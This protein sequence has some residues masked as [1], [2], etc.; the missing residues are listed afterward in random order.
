M[1]YEQRFR[2]IMQALQTG[3]VTPERFLRAATGHLANGQEGLS[4][5]MKDLGLATTEYGPPPNVAANGPTVPE[6]D[7][8]TLSRGEPSTKPEQEET[9]LWEAPKSDTSPSGTNPAS[10]YVLEGEKA[11]KQGGIGEVW[12][13]YDRHLDRKVAIKRLRR[14]R[15]GIRGLRARFELEAKITAQLQHP[16][17]V[18]CFDLML[19][20][21]EGAG[22]PWYT[23]RFIEG[24]TLARAIVE[25]HTNR[26]S[27]LNLRRLIEVLIS[28]C[29]TVAFA[30]ARDVLHR[31]LK[32][33]NIILGEFG[34]VFVLDW[35]L[36]K[37]GATEGEVEGPSSIEPTPPS[38]GGLTEP[39]T[40]LGTPA[41]MAPEMARGEPAHKLCDVYALG[42]ILY[43][44]LTGRPPYEGPTP[45]EIVHS[46]E[47]GAP[48][49][50]SEIKSGISP[51]LEAICLKAM[52]RDRANR[53]AT[54]LDLADELR[55]WLADEPVLAYPDPW[56]VRLTRWGRRHRTIAAAA[57]V[58]FA[59]T[60]TSMTAA[61]GLLLQ[62]NAETAQARDELAKALQDVS[63]ARDQANDRY[64]LAREVIARILDRVVEQDL[65]PLIEVA[66]LRR[67]LSRT[68]VGLMQVLNSHKPNDWELKRDFA[69]V[70]FQAG[71]VHRSL[72]ETQ[73]ATTLY[74]NS[75]ERL[76]SLVAERHED[77]EAALHLARCLLE[78]ADLEVLRGEPSQ[79]LPHLDEA[80]RVIVDALNRTGG[81][82]AWRVLAGRARLA[83]G[84]VNLK[85]G[86]ADAAK[87]QSNEAAAFLEAPAGRNYHAT[88]LAIINKGNQA[89]F[90]LYQ[91]DAPRARDLARENVDLLARLI[92]GDPN[93]NNLLYLRARALHTLG[94]ALAGTE[95]PA[96]A[97]ASQDEALNILEGLVQRTKKVARYTQ[98]LAALKRDQARQHPHES[99]INDL[100]QSLALLR[101]LVD[102]HPN[103]PGFQTELGL[104]LAACARVKGNQD[105]A[106]EARD[107]LEKAAQREPGDPEV[108]AARAELNAKE[109]R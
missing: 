13:A 48:R 97:E 50:P 87:I 92:N 26:P 54:V 44:M 76:R 59:A 11:H 8:A 2:L 30:H 108:R 31:D 27:A 55:H 85:L 93:N 65:P 95:D 51:P 20:G 47:Q 60:A 62:A 66:E 36:A 32:G 37:A 52:A 71:N 28:V 43:A 57:L 15:L 58:G 56:T 12:L 4:D 45:D 3:E 102:R 89:Y 49:R 99:A 35:G 75:A 25:H 72:Y 38:G 41:Y 101:E 17:I 79:A 78:R 103:V 64:H 69:I 39:G 100:D 90:A 19:T 33:D 61:S 42:A 6:L 18:P 29:Q 86:R 83:R 1:D 14:D 80:D 21:Q 98:A 74:T 107:L 7:D 106:K 73:E 46:I 105:E 81:A 34:E 104:T 94:L 82:D 88:L 96:A 24:K 53:Y 70:E 10:R 16:G 84:L 67:D 9:P 5:V 109:S 68:S 22:G 23:M 91:D 63:I 77:A 40:K